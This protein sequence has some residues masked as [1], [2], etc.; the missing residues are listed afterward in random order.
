MSLD[1]VFEKPAIES[2]EDKGRAFDIFIKD[3][4]EIYK[5]NPDTLKKIT[6]NYSNLKSQYVDSNIL[7]LSFYG[8]T[9]LPDSIGNLNSLQGLELSRNDLSVLPDSIGNLGSLLYLFLKDNNLSV[10][11]DS[12]GN[13]KSLK[14]LYLVFNK[15]SVLPDSFGSL[16]SL[17]QLYLGFNNLSVLPDSFGSLRSLQYLELGSNKLS[18]LPNTIGSL[19]S[20]KRLNL[21]NNNLS[22]LPESIIKN[23]IIINALHYESCFNGAYSSACD[24]FQK[25]GVGRLIQKLSNG[26]KFT[27][28]MEEVI[29]KY[30][31]NFQIFTPQIINFLLS[32]NENNQGNKEKLSNFMKKYNY[33]IIQQSGNE[34]KLML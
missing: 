2:I 25:E 15:L 32:K 21:D 10:L 30:D 23:K 5:E 27:S 16:R 33:S 13:L 34:I 18:V 1:E 29:E 4:K 11:P 26:E 8:L 3:L 12:I 31:P 24:Y 14:Q 17:Q 20:L 7:N 9:Q 19:K 28:E 6:E 22:V